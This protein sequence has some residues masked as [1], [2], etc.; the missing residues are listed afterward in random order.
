[1]NVNDY[2]IG[3]S[4]K[5]TS[6]PRAPGAPPRDLIKRQGVWLHTLISL[7]ILAV[8]ALLGWLIVMSGAIR[9]Q[10]V[11]T[12]LFAPPVLAGFLVTLELTVLSMLIGVALGIAAALMVRSRVRSISWV[13]KAYIWFFR[14]TPV[15]VQLIFWFNMSLVFPTIGFGTWTLPTNDVITPFVAALLGLGINEGAYMSEIFRAGLDS[16]DKGQTEAGLASGMTPSQVMRRVVLPQALIV[17]TPPTGNQAIGML[18]TTS[19]VSVIA[20]QDLLTKVQH[21][22]ATN[23]QVIDLLIVAC[24]WYLLATSVA[25]WGQ[26]K[27]ERSFAGADPDVVGTRRWRRGRTSDAGA[28]D[29]QKVSDHE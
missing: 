28:G 18:K 25:T 15:L 16:V 29:L 23:Y 13:G 21:I 20:A 26:S 4:R 19:L 10:T 8:V 3:G 2:E 22:Y 1:M 12:Y 11:W 7:A 24:F 6:L 14:G 9:W 27:L 5:L 17:I